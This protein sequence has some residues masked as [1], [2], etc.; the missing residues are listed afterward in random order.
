MKVLIVDDNEKNRKLLCS[1]LTFRNVEVVEAKTGQDA[2]GLVTPQIAF[3]VVD[4]RLPDIDGYEVA[5]Q[6]KKRYP[7]MPLIA[8]TA[9]VLAEE[10]K[11]LETAGLFDAVVLKPIDL[12]IFNEV[13]DVLLKAQ[14]EKAE[15]GA[16]AESSKASPPDT[17]AP[18]IC[19][20]LKIL[21]VEDNPVNQRL[22][23]FLLA[24]LGCQ[25]ESAGNGKVAVEKVSAGHYDLILMDLQMPVMSGCEAARIIRDTIDKTIPIIAVTAAAMKEDE[26][27]CLASGM[28]DFI[29]KPVDLQQ[30]TEKIALWGGR[31]GESRAPAIATSKA[32]QT[33]ITRQRALRELGITEEMY[34]E[35][36]GIFIQQSEQTLVDL[37]SAVARKDFQDIKRAAHYVKG[38]AG[39]LR[40]DEVHDVAQEIEQLAAAGQGL[41]TILRKSRDLVVLLD[42]VKGHRGK[43]ER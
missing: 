15:S 27:E 18:R 36:I 42:M 11:K 9:S 34:D 33:S 2:L 1:L 25:M 39:N 7:Q 24:K 5:R 23:E 26:R 38:S 8:C 4:I 22:L 31:K 30:L 3:C 14:G 35:L 17:H 6:I 16:G 20:G 41:E 10:K 37:A 13:V 12:K 21:V 40:L 43:G 19:K 29:S 32:D 28:N